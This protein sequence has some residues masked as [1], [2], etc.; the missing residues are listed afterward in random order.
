MMIMNIHDCMM[1]RM[2]CRTVLIVSTEIHRDVDSYCKSMGDLQFHL[3]TNESST[4]NGLINQGRFDR[5]GN[6]RSAEN[7]RLLFADS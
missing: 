2:S 1:Q 5:N 4:S 3:V 6:Q 7:Q